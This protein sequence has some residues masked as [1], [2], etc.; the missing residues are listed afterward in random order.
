MPRLLTR[1][2]APGRSYSAVSCTRLRCSWRCGA[3][4]SGGMSNPILWTAGVG[5]TFCVW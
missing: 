4:A 5:S 1:A 2:A 3:W